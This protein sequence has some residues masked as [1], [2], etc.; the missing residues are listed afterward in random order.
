[1]SLQYGLIEYLWQT[2]VFTEPSVGYYCFFIG[3]LLFTMLAAYLLGSINSAIIISKLV[4]QDD[5]RLHGSGNPGLTNM[6]R[7]FGALPALFTLLGDLLKTVIAILIAGF[8]FGFYYAGGVSIGDG[9]CYIAALCAVLGHIF[10]AFYKFKGGKGVLAIATSALMLSPI[11]FLILFAIF[12]IIVFITRYI[13]LGS[14]VAVIF[15]PVIMYAYFKVAFPANPEEGFT[16]GIPGIISLCLILLAIII[17]WR[18]KENLKRI[19]DR[20]EHKFTF[21]RKKKDDAE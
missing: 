9:L 17:V 8:F 13:S 11:P 6:F 18:H 16:G 2:Q 12:V 14:V 20:S 1:M 7:T 15:Y 19:S 3:V 5:V 10:P 21:K 4:C